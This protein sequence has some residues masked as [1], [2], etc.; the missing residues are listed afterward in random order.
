VASTAAG[1]D[2]LAV[3]MELSQLPKRPV[4]GLAHPGVI[5]VG[6]QPA[7]DLLERRGRPV[8]HDPLRQHPVAGDRL[9]R[10]G[11]D[12]GAA[13][14][15]LGLEFVDERVASDRELG[16]VVAAAGLGAS[17]ESG[18][19]PDSGQGDQTHEGE[20]E[21]SDDLRTNWRVSQHGLVPCAS[22]SGAVR[23]SCHG[24]AGL[25]L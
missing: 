17:S 21:D 11:R 12:P 1:V 6:V 8:D 7:D 2:H 22:E 10:P 23:A 19:D 20:G 15:P 9:A 25:S 24:A 3:G 14:H 4:E 5:G 13:Q 18:S 16:Q